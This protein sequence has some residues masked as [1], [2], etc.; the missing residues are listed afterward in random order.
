MTI[1]ERPLYGRIAIETSPWASSFSWTDR[2][3]T[4]VDGIRYSE[5]GRIGTPG[6]SQV[7]VGTLTA[8]FKDA[9]TV[10]VV[11]DLVRV[12]RYGTSEYFWVGY[13]QDVS[14]RIVFGNRSSNTA[15]FVMTTI[16]CNDWVGYISQFQAVGAGGVTYAT[17]VIKTTS[18]YNWRDR[19]GALNKIID[20]AYATALITA[21]AGSP[22]T[23]NLGD[24]DLVGTFAEH[25]NLFAEWSDVVWFGTHTLPT[26]QTTGRTDLIAANFLSSLVSS[27]KTFTDAAG[28]SGQLH[29]TEIDF[30]NTTQNI[31]NNIVVNNRSRFNIP[32]V[33]S[34]ISKIGGFNENNYVVVNNTNVVGVLNEAT[35]S[36]LST[37]SITSYGNRQATF[38]TCVSLI[39]GAPSNSASNL[40]ANP[41][42]EYSDDGYFGDST[43]VVRRRKPTEDTNPFSAYDGLWAMRMR[44]KGSS[45]ASPIIAYTGSEADGTPVVAGNSYTFFGWAARGIPNRTDVRVRARIKWY[46][47]DEAA[48]STVYGSQTSLS[49]SSTWV[50]VTSGSQTAPAGAVRAQ[51]AM[52][53]NRSGG[54]NFSAGDVLWADA[55]VLTKA[56]DTTYWDGDTAWDSL[57]GY[58]WTGGNGASPSYRVL[59][60]VDNVATSMLTKYATTSMRVSRIRWNAQEDLTAVSSLTVGKTISL[61]YK[62]TTTTYRIVGTDGTVDPDRY[63][64]DY[65]LAKV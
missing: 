28:T 19:V 56:S 52:E 18:D 31:A 3:S 60:Y 45:N 25:L 20:P 33:D 53:Y 10:P 30:E 39:P 22:S 5:G 38:D 65:Y 16:Y 35:Q 17:G 27:S 37:T 63:M 8:T 50:R 62:S 1:L 59:N 55:F 48:I 15:P 42:V 6:T 26:N 13:V 11:G 12:K 49:S 34:E 40:L 57:Y 29:Y 64:I 58:L 23:P 14:Q 54:G 24:S 36:K 47:A 9:A 44:C 7:D 32:S 43:T 46:D 61:V 4:L 2:T 51:V 41:S 21:Q